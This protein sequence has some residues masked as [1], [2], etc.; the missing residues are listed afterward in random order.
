MRSSIV[1]RTLL[2]L[3]LTAL[4]C[5][6]GHKVATR[7]SASGTTSNI[8]TDGDK[9]VAYLLGAATAAGSKGELHVA[10]ADGN[11]VD[12]AGGISAG[13]Y[14]LAPTGKALF[15]SKLNAAGDDA[16]LSWLD[17][18]KPGAQP[19]VLFDRGMKVEDAP[20]GGTGK[21]TTALSQLAFFTPSG[22][23]YVVG[24]LAPGVDVSPDLHVIDVATGNDVYKAGNG[25]FDYLEAAL[26]DDT[27]IFQDSV[28]GNSGPSGPPPVETLFW[29]SLPAAGT[30]QPAVIDTRTGAFQFSGD[31]KLMVYQRISR[32]LMAWDTVARPAT[33]TQLASNALA[34]AVS[35]SATGPIAYIGSDRSVHVV[36]ASGTALVDVPAAT[37]AADLL[38]PIF[39]S[40]DGN[41]VYYFQN[42]ATQDRRGTLMHLA[43]TAGA[44]PGKIAD[45]ASIVDVHPV[46][47][48]LL[49]LANLDSVGDFGDG[50]RSARD[51]SGAT[52]LG[53]RVPV[54]SLLLSR[55]T[56][57]EMPWLSAHLTMATTDKAKKLVDGAEATVGALALT[58]MAG[59]GDATVDPSVR[60]G[61]F[62]VGDDLQNLLYAGG[63]AFDPMVNNY[64]GSLKQVAVSSP[65]SPS[66]E[67]VGG[68]SE[69]GSV[70]GHALFVNAPKAK[71]PGV[72]FVRF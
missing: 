9:H 49:Y 36:S 44:T 53:T 48:G 58:A 32:E 34:F 57:A 59:G 41:D 25:A 11:D 72:Y 23:Y 8:V 68:V 18:T 26:P 19:K 3:V 10:S 15:F 5:G 35:G 43:A 16:S 30:S 40:S 60:A 4:G 28:G 69:V 71:T 29:L 20:G 47:G 7:V 62:A 6:D 64:V 42:V 46:A 24:V 45:A 52:A 37:A 1:R 54:G 31:N 65:T 12:V 55:P 27:M 67:L 13:A 51:G 39:L 33:P 63:V 2:I 38:S 14:V 70:V 17:L 21:I 66:K 56:M 61:Q 22:N 50:V